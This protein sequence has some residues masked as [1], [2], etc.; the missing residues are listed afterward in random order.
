[1]CASCETAWL[2]MSKSKTFSVARDHQKKAL[3]RWEF[4]AVVYLARWHG[5]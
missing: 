2:T 3:P 1:M 4:L 5:S